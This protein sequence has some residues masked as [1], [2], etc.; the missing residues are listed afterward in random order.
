MSSNIVLADSD[1]KTLLDYYRGQTDPD[2]RLRAHILLL[3][4]DGHSWNLIVTMLYSSSRTI[5]RWKDRFGAYN[6]DRSRFW[7]WVHLCNHSSGETGDYSALG[8]LPRFRSV[9]SSPRRLA[10]R[11]THREVPYGWPRTTLHESLRVLPP[12]ATH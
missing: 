11:C 10:V 7:P 2:L 3:L 1:R 4:A 8:G 5:A 6:R 9:D 12:F